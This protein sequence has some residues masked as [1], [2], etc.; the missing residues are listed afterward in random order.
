MDRPYLTML[1]SLRDRLASEDLTVL[2]FLCRDLIKASRMDNIHCPLDLF[3][4]LEGCG[5]LAAGR[6]QVLA[7]LLFEAQRID[8]MR[9][10]GIT[11]DQLQLMLADNGPKLS[12]YRKMLHRLSEHMVS[13]DVRQFKHILKNTENIQR[14]RLE[15]ATD[16]Y[17]LFAL[18]ERL[19][20]INSS[21]VSCL[22]AITDQMDEAGLSAI[23]STYIEEHCKKAAATKDV[24]IQAPSLQGFAEGI[25]E[26][27]IRRE[28]KKGI[29]LII[30]NDNFT[31]NRSD[32]LCN[33]DLEGP[34]KGSAKDAA[35][36]KKVFTDLHF[37]VHLSEN[38]TRAQLK[39]HAVDYAK[40]DHSDY[41]IFVC[42]ILTHG[43]AGKVFGIDCLP[44]PLYDLLLKF[45]P[46]H[47]P[48]L[49]D[50]PKVFFVQACQ[51]SRVEEE[52]S[53]PSIDGPGEEI[54]NDLEMDYSGKLSKVTNIP[55]Q[56]DYFLG[57]ATVPGYVSYRSK[58]KGS[59]Y[60][61]ALCEMLSRHHNT[62]D[63]LSIVTQ[64]NNKVTEKEEKNKK[65]IAI[66]TPLPQY[67]LRKQIYLRT[68]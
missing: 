65:F 56:P 30:N 8:L 19:E 17:A 46:Y 3:D 53:I 38:L 11:P 52:V 55:R 15:E 57:L 16:P 43:E 41:D 66:Q 47:C 67:T 33:T 6:L 40:M 60:I 18:L 42:C 44:I 29:C 7:E 20:K 27:K 51:G 4:A 35:S 37:D 61:Q 50:K 45:N 49:K 2:K 28:G 21:D 9:A 10:T 22:L 58:T 31:A 23:V 64:V 54:S 5:E 24:S 1:N 13:C 62:T 26:Y 14:S 25:P 68:K 12:A 32:T 59:W 48:T 36:L 63:L 34:R 39:Q